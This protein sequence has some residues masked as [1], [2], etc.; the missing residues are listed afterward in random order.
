M[1]VDEWAEQARG[2]T[3]TPEVLTESSEGG[4]LTSGFDPLE[5][6]L[7]DDEQ[8]HFVFTVER[9]FSGVWDDDLDAGSHIR[10]VATDQ[11]LRTISE[12]LDMVLYYDSLGGVGFLVRGD[13][14]TLILEGGG[15]NT[16]YLV[17]SPNEAD[18]VA[19]LEEAVQYIRHRRPPT[20]R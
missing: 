4:L 15:S 20:D 9:V 11:Y 17:R 18:V 14:C 7:A 3:V 1:N 2:A 5:T 13:R 16:T 6:Y 19:E 8:P 10:V 12:T